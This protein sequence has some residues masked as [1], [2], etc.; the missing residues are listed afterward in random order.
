MTGDPCGSLTGAK[1]EICRGGR[2]DQA[3]R[4]KYLAKWVERGEVG[5]EAVAYA[6]THPAATE[7]RPRGRSGSPRSRPKLLTPADLPCGFRGDFL[8][9]VSCVPC[10]S[11]GR[12]GAKVYEC[13]LHGRCMMQ[14]FS[15]RDPAKNAVACVTCDDREASLVNE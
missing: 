12:D 10:R 13:R 11:Q 6:E 7:K 15:A 14:N 2:V 3:T 1:A 4:L 8:E 5:P 9:T